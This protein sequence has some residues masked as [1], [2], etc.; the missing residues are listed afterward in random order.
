MQV[1]ERMLHYAL[2]VNAT[3]CT[4]SECYT[5]QVEER[6]LHY[7]VEERMLHYAVEERMLHYALEVNATLCK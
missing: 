1:E 2:E 6:M 4:R 5:M 3:L 7:A